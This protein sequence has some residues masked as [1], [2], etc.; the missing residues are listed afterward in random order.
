MLSKVFRLSVGRMI[1]L[2]L[3]TMGLVAGSGVLTGRTASA[4]V[5][6]DFGIGDAVRVAD[7][8]LNLRADAGLDAAI[9]DVVPDGAVFVVRDGPVSQDG[10]T[11][12][13]VFNYG[14]GTGWM[15][16]EFLSYDAGG[17][18]SD[19]EREGG[20]AIGDAIRVVDGPVNFRDGAGLDANI[21]AVVPD[22]E[23]FVVREGP[24]AADGYLWVEVFNYGYGTGWV[25]AE[26][27]AL[28]PD[29]FPSEGGQ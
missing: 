25:A 14:Y 2:T 15:A 9:L 3:L 13:Q 18:P 24:V 26:F 10:Y 4:V 27:F 6:A 16:A 22:G 5:L 17:F 8:P 23:L 19:G 20:F 12:V 29:G 7:G 11:W 1:V 21:L 28:E